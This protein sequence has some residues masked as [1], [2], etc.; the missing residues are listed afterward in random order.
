MVCYLRRFEDFGQLDGAGEV[1]RHRG[2][3][4]ER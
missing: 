4:V 2:E 1:R 3:V